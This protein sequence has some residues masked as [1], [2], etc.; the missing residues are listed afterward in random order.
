MFEIESWSK[1]EVHSVSREL[2]FS[3]NYMW[4]LMEDWIGKNCPE[5][6][7]SNDFQKLSEA[8]GAY[9]AQRLD[10]TIDKKITGLDR[11][12]QFLKYSHWSAFEDIELTKLSDKSLRMRTIGC[13]A[14]KAAKKRGMDC[15]DCSKG[16]LRIRKGFFGRID[17]TAQVVRIFTPPDKKPSEIPERVSCEWIISIK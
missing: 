10:N 3:L 12:M 16:S 15:Y 9:E 13:T 11:V 14:Q 2:L 4:F 7:D 6:V 1:S 5:K 8:F 17:S